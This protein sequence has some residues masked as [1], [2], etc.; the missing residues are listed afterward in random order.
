MSAELNKA[1][2]DDQKIDF[3]EILD[4]GLKLVDTVG[5]DVVDTKAGL[6]IDIAKQLIKWLDD[7]SED[8]VITAGECLELIEAVALKLGYDFDKQGIILP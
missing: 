3:N 1:Y 5:E 6:Y 2:I 7:A 4:I 8:G